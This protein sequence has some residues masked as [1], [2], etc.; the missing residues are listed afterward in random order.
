MRREE[1]LAFDHQREFD[2]VFPLFLD[3]LIELHLLHQ[4]GSPGILAQ[5]TI[6]ELSKGGHCGARECFS[7]PSVLG[8]EALT[9]QVWLRILKVHDHVRD[10]LK[11]DVICERDGDGISLWHVF[12]GLL[13]PAPQNSRALAQLKDVVVV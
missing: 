1:A 7:N 2:L 4:G 3:P 12:G 9:P 5:E 11:S 6:K 10:L 13:E 8:L